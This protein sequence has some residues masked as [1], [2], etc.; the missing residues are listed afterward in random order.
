MSE[1]REPLTLE[2]MRDMVG[3][4]V[5]VET[6]KRAEWCILWGYHGPEVIGRAMIFTTRTASKNQLPFTEYGKTWT[7]YARELQTL[8]RSAWEPCE[9]CGEW[10]GGECTPKEQDAGYTLYAGYSKQVAVDDFWEDEIEDVQYCPKCGR[11]L[12]EEAWKELER[13][14]FGE[15]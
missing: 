3:K 10:I 1:K 5:W 14:L 6:S 2:Q 13:R 7:A 11:P 12:T 8:D 4:P 15:M 9:F